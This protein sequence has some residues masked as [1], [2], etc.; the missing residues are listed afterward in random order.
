VHV[1]TRIAGVM[2]LAVAVLAGVLTARPASAQVDLSGIWGPVY[3]EDQ[4]ERIP[5]P[6]LGDYF[7][8][9]LSAGAR[10]FAESWDSGR[11]SLPEHQCRVH[12]VPYIYRG[13]NR[14][15]VW[16]E[17]DPETQR[18]IA[19]KHRISTFA[20]LR[21][22]WMDGRPHPSENARHTWMGFS[23]GRFEGDVL[24]VK[25]TH[26]KQNWYRRNGLP[27]SD[28]A[29]MT[30]YFARHGE[31]LTR[32]SI[33]EDPV[34]LTE[35]LIKSENFLRAA[36]P[37]DDSWVWPCESVSEVDR[38]PEDVPHYLPGANPYLSEFLQPL[39]LPRVV[40]EGG[41][42]QMYPEYMLKL[43]ELAGTFKPSR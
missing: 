38:S 1:K 24:V 19:I 36:R 34:Y 8:L 13:P 30:E 17:R 6:S 4:P 40:G 9:P 33:V 3:H 35:P 11:L 23:T 41:A 14:F 43:R 5:G 26:I 7:G 27:Q 18:L 29:T 2:H 12:T 39:H 25:T 32:T 20:Q 10:R 16:E 42:E 37:Q 15:R 31:V 28:Q 22:I 21:T